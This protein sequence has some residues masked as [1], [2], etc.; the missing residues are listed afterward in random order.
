M[1]PCASAARNRPPAPL[2]SSSAARAAGLHPEDR[3][4]ESVPLEPH[5]RGRTG[6]QPVVTR[7]HRGSSPREG[8]N[9]GMA[10]LGPRHAV[11]TRES[12]GSNPPPL[13][14][15]G[16]AQLSAERTSPKR[17]GGGSSPS[18]GAN[19]FLGMV[20]VVQRSERSNVDRVMSVRFRSITPNIY[21]GLAESG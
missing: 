3:R 7:D 4:F 18:T 19:F 15:A 10:E 8:A 21:G 16:V 9:Q 2:P 5:P 13:T 14:N 12:G 20:V 11:R 17:G 6:R 1:K